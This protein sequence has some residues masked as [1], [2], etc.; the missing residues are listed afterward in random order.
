MNKI[1]SNE[2]T[3]EL[4][5]LLK[6]KGFDYHSLYNDFSDNYDYFDRTVQGRVHVSDF[7]EDKFP[8]SDKWFP[9]PYISQVIDWLYEKHNLW[10]E[11]IWDIRIN[12]Q[13][14][15][16]SGITEIGNSSELEIFQSKPCASPT[17]AYVDAIKYCLKQLIKNENN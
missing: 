4:T 12:K 3:F 2:V 17:E 7:S 9:V 6:E 5:K 13:L 11:V 14:R 16:Y 10:I 8:D 1:L 15:W